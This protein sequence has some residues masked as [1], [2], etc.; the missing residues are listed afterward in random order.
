MTCSILDPQHI[1]VLRTFARSRVLL[2]FDYDGTLSPIAPTPAQAVLPDSTR[3]LLMVV[4]RHFPVAIISGR[5][6]ADI[7]ARV[8]DIGVTHIFGNHGLERRGA[9]SRPHPQVRGWVDRLRHQLADQAGV[10]IEDKLHSVSVHFRA[11]P[12]HDQALQV[13]M[14]V[15]GALPEAR[16]ILGAA[17]VNLLPG[18]AANKGAALRQAFEDSGCQKAIYVGDDET[19]EDAFAGLRPETLLSIRMGASEASRARYHLD[20]Q[21]SIDRLLRALVDA[22]TQNSELETRN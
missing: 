7:S 18:A 1:S 14:P 16:V 21:E 15:V 11:A 17:A 5:A 2:A 13:I 12:D 9:V 19:D 22:R 3:Q 4:A 10:V 20:G 6:L 8:A